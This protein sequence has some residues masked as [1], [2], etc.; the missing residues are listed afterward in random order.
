MATAVAE[1]DTELAFLSKGDYQ[2]ILKGNLKFNI[3]NNKGI[4][5]LTYIF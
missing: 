2:S 4:F 5:Y 3:Y 1:V